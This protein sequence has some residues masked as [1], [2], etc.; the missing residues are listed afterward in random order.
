M[1]RKLLLFL[2]LLT[3]C[4]AQAQNYGNEW[5]NYSQQYFKVKVWQDGIHR[6]DRQ[7]LLFAGIPVTTIDP[8]KIQLFHN[9]EQQ[10]IHIEGQAD[11]SFDTGDFIEF[12][13]RKNDGAP[14]AAL[15]ADPNWQPN[16]HY[17]LFTDT[18][19][20]FI[21]WSVTTNGLRM[22]EESDQTFSNFTAADYC[23]KRSFNQLS[24]WYNAGRNDN[25]IEYTESEGWGYIFGNNRYTSLNVTLNTANVYGAGPDAVLETSI[26]GYNNLAHNILLT[27]FGLN[28]S[29][30]YYTQALKRYTFQVPCSLIT[31][32]SSNLSYAVT[33]P[34]T[35]GTDYNIY[36]YAALTY[37]HTFDFENAGR[38]EFSLPNATGQSKSRLDITNFSSSGTPIL[39]DLNN[40][41][42]ISV[43]ANG[44]DW[45]ALIPNDGGTSPKNCILT[46]TGSIIPAT[47]II[48]INY[49]ANNFGYFNNFL[50]NPIDSA[51]LIVT[52]RSL[53]NQAQLYKNYRNQTTGNRVLLADIDELTD[54]FA[55]GIQKHPHSIRNFSKLLLDQWTNVADPQ[56]LFLLGKSINPI[57]ARSNSALFAVSLIPSF[58]IPSSDIVLTS[59]LNGTLYEPAIPTGRLS[60]RTGN[61]ILGYLQKVQEYEAVQQG[62]P[63]SWMK[64][65]LHF[66]GGN[67]LAQQA[68]LAG[69]LSDFE[70]I[71][72]GA[73]F[74]GNV[75]TYLKFNTSPIVIN[76]SDSLQAQIDSG[77]AVMTF[78]GHASG[79]GFDQST[80]DPS[81]YSN[82]GRYPL[83]VANSCFA[84]DIH[85]NSKSVSERF[86]LEPEKAAIGF[87]A[88]VGQGIPQ[89]LFQYSHAFFENASITNYGAT[90]G[91]LMKK[92]IQA[93]QIPN[94]EN[95]K[96]VCQEMSLNGDPSI[97]IN[98][99]DKPDFAVNESAIRFPS[100][101]ITTDR[102]TFTVRVLTRNLGKAVPD[103]FAVKLTRTFPDGTDSV[104]SIPRGNCFYEDDLA[105]TIKTGGFNAAGLNRFTVVIDPADSVDEYDNFLNNTAST[106]LFITSNDIIPVYPVKFAIHPN[107]TVDLKAST[108]NPLAGWNSY[109]F[110]IDTVDLNLADSIPTIQHSSLF[111]TTII[112]DSGGVI[113]WNI[114]NYL[115]VDSAVYYW[116]V[117]ND[118]ISIDP[119][120]YKWQQSSF[121]YIPNKAGW[122]QSDFYQFI[123][124]GF[125]N[126]LFDTLNRKFDYVQNNKLLSVLTKG[127]PDGS[128]AGF[129]EIGYQ[130]NNVITEYN[131]CTPIPSVF[132][133]VLD[134]ITLNPWST[135]G[136]NFN[137]YNQYTLI[138]GDC[139]D[140]TN[141]FGTGSCRS[142]PENV[143]MFQLPDTNQLNGFA[144]M[145][146]SIP[147]GNFVLLYSWFTTNYSIVDPVFLNT[148]NSLGLNTNGLNDNAPFIF[149]TKKGYQ[150]YNQ[151]VFGQNQTDT[152][153]LNALL[154]TQWTRGTINSTTIGPARI[155]ESLHWNQAP[156]ETGSTADRVSVNIFGLNE[157]TARWDTLYRGL[158][159]T[160]DGKDTTLNWISAYLYPY[161]RLQSYTQDDSLRTPPQMDYWR[162]YYEPVPE[163]AINPNRT[164]S[165]YKDPL[166]EGDTLRFSIAIDNISDLPMD[167]LDVD[168]YL[169]N[170]S[171]QRINLNTVRLDSL[172]TGG[173]LLASM[174]IDSTLGLSGSNSL[175]VEA[176]PFNSRHQLE[177]YH[178]NNLA[179]IKFRIERDKINPILDVTFDGV[180]IL[181]GDIVSGRPNIT[182]Q[183]QDENRFL[184]LNDT[185][186]FKV[187]LRTPGNSTLQRIYFGLPSHGNNLRFTPAVLP[188]NSCRIDWLP[189][190]SVDGTYILEVEAA[191]VS[192]NESG[193]YNYKI[194]FEVINRS[195]ITEV[196][197]YPNP[198]S[199]STRFVFTLTGNEVP[200]YMK[201]QIMTVTGKVVREI[202][203]SELGNIHVGRN[204]TEYAWDGKDEFG[205]Q[206]ANGLYLY[207]VIT[208][209]NG[210]TIEKR[211]TDADFYFKKGW[212]KMYLMR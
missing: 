142:R 139:N 209:I 181:D 44:A 205:D 138:S 105:I 189:T 3:C 104:Y 29:D 49:I 196:L 50:S 144:T 25:S 183:L 4:F 89:D 48:G 97:R 59:G 131:G 58:G 164:F 57:D 158:N 38:F 94:A 112:D 153:T 187:Y 99:W 87:I 92:A 132:V 119:T 95:L 46:S 163:C 42:R 114:P 162:I 116:R 40:H 154:S 31:A 36:H 75:T 32:A 77:V 91:L 70:N 174:R 9:G 101:A 125:E 197:N 98:H 178:F 122:A 16:I 199:T 88:S 41:K 35:S 191:D 212:G 169:Y 160:A 152:L 14:D 63:Q 90:V 118:S 108:S 76:Q 210:E 180:H 15:Y 129:N 5:I 113:T 179:E 64:E 84:G 166:T 147:P 127:L 18:S 184:A 124:D 68:Q 28:F 2:L 12:M 8:R 186:K 85:T 62:V 135:C 140:P 30:T 117:A 201:I 177:Q 19:V 6:I 111:N 207:R 150:T 167:S 78:F 81:E 52:H 123:E 51:F 157:V 60:A 43:A 39:Y 148:I 143:F 80:D 110:E 7:T 96:I 165:F 33:T 175:W 34:T 22:T 128:Q 188:K 168:F 176:N 53:W 73:Q 130:L 195:T 47:S 71:M 21:T 137:Q 82:R 55:Y 149:L 120:K 155:W 171:R 146:N 190:F 83:V 17:S 13:G 204:I 106:S 103:S 10:Y 66:G 72:E 211:A 65:I 1:K 109:R 121:M 61:E 134:S 79:A 37:P 93:I 170:N 86:V 141:A 67:D 173:S 102:D 20:Y 126:I 115:L 133:A 161:L 194:S 27:Y 208:S 54:Q 107:N 26:S 100:S 202:T 24:G 151:T 145:M 192:N 198:F 203:Q 11:G 45:Q 136:R 200:T 206:L 156:R 182:V 193:K 56:H 74:G 172:R 23:L 185:A 159:Y 69:Y